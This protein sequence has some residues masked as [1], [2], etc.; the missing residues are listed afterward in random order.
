MP[1]PGEGL[2]DDVGMMLIDSSISSRSE[3]PAGEALR[4]GGWMCADKVIGC[5]CACGGRV[6][7]CARC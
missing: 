2:V 1:R 6:C 7:G 4:W 5:L 3:T